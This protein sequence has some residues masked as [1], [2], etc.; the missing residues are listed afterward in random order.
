MV[1]YGFRIVFLCKLI[2]KILKR[3]KACQ[4]CFYPTTETEDKKKN[5]DHFPSQTYLGNLTTYKQLV[6]VAHAFNPSVREAEAGGSK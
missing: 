2:P 3:K 1:L 6:I 4:T 5:E